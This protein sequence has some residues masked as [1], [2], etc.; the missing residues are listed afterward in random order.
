MGLGVLDGSGALP[1]FR[2]A[3]LV[4]FDVVDFQWWEECVQF[5]ELAEE[6]AEI[7][8]DKDVGWPDAAVRMAMCM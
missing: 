1:A 6:Y 7:C 8:V 4:C 3:V 2:G 5:F